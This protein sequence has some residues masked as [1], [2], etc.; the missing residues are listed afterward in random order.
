MRL[1]VPSLDTFSVVGC[2]LFFR[3]V[4]LTAVVFWKVCSFKITDIT[5][6]CLCCRFSEMEMKERCYSNKQSADIIACSLSSPEKWKIHLQSSGVVTVCVMQQIQ[7]LRTVG[8]ILLSEA[9]SWTSHWI[10]QRFGVGIWFFFSYE[11]SVLKRKI[12]CWERWQWILSHL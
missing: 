8:H 9:K 10:S 12:A 2:C 6:L 3:M 4:S 5:V 1:S 11:I 7:S